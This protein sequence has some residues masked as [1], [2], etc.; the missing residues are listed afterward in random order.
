MPSWLSC[1]L[2]CFYIKP[3][4]YC[5]ADCNARG[6]S[7]FCFYI[8][9]QQRL[10]RTSRSIV[11]PYSVSTSNHNNPNTISG[12]QPVV[13]YSVS[14]SNH[15]I[16]SNGLDFVELFLILFLHQTTTLKRS[17]IFYHLLFL[18]LFLHQTTTF[19]KSMT[20]L[21]KLFLILFL[22][23]TTTCVAC[24]VG[25]ASCS[26]FCFYIKPQRDIRL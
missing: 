25:I 3:Q 11:V 13:P 12:A 2:F 5:L 6:C 22:H 4:L 19:G 15:N 16:N 17:T 21:G 18:I 20:K 10:E 8:K 9:P 14:T 23:Q 24:T 1:S 26:L 7:L